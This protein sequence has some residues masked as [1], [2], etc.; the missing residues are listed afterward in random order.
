VSE[1]THQP[2]AKRLREAREKGQ[3]PNS[4][5]WTSAGVVVG[6]WGGALVGMPMGVSRLV[7]F[8]TALFQRSDQAVPA[9]LDESVR[10]LAAFT[11]PP[12]A[13]AMVGALV[14]AMF[15]VGFKFHFPLV[16]PKFERLN[17]VEG[18]KKLFSL[19]RLVDVLKSMAV[20]LILGLVIFAEVHNVLPQLFS[21][22]R[23]EDPAAGLPH[24]LLMIRTIL[25][26]C[27]VLFIVIGVLDFMWARHRHKK[28]LMMTREEAKQEHKENE[29]DPHHKAMR[30]GLHRQYANGGPARGVQK[31]TAVVVNPTHVSVALRYEPSECDAPYLVAKGQEYDALSIRREAAQLGIPVIRDVPLARSLIHYDVGEEIPEE[32]Y[33]AVAALLKA[34]MEKKTEEAKSKR[35][36][37]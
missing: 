26:H 2:T 24:G 21:I 5:L 18:L 22:W 17:P 16:L 9:A 14:T 11:A 35:G 23:L 20:V 27:L 25:V 32:L 28:D 10:V 34:A 12:L 37:V 1:K 30:K 8:T 31:A 36:T 29:G 6:A 15:A 7:P 4:R 19:K 13:G 33:Q 3:V